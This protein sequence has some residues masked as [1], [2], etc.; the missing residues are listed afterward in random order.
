MGYGDHS[1]SLPIG[2]PR[3]METRQSEFFDQVL[4]YIKLDPKTTTNP[5]VWASN[6]NQALVDFC[7]HQNTIT[8]RNAVGAIPWKTRERSS[9]LQTLRSIG[10]EDEALTGLLDEIVRALGTKKEGEE[11]EKRPRAT[12]GARALKASTRHVADAKSKQTSSSR[13]DA[14]SDSDSL[15]LLH[16]ATN[17]VL[18]DD[19]KEAATATAT[20]T[21]AAATATEKAKKKKRVEKEAA[22]AA[23]AAEAAAAEAA[24]EK[25]KKAAAAAVAEKAAAAAAAEKAE[26]ERIAKAASVSDSRSK[27]KRGSLLP[28]MAGQ[29]T[30]IKDIGKVVSQPV[31]RSSG[32]ERPERRAGVQ[33]QTAPSSDSSSESGNES[34]GSPISS[35]KVARH[36]MRVVQGSSQRSVTASPPL[37]SATSVLEDPTTPEVHTALTAEDIELIFPSVTGFPGFTVALRNG[38][39][40]LSQAETPSSVRIFAEDLKAYAFKFTRGVQE[41]ART[42][43]LLG[44][45]ARPGASKTVDRVARLQVQSR[46]GAASYPKASSRN[47]T[48]PSLDSLSDLDSGSKGVS[49]PHSS[50]EVVSSARDNPTTVDV[51]LRGSD[52]GT[53]PGLRPSRFTGQARQMSSEALAALRSLREMAR[54]GSS[55][56]PPL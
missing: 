38:E 13:T 19:G 50:H 5:A 12:D 53:D 40:T 31:I 20:A 34:D 32:M 46:P 37:S 30:A 24:V 26:K 33:V 4:T 23:A 6:F 10:L 56:P 28:V 36:S 2:N 45:A 29:T 43:P 39:L 16:D 7:G 47:P 18:T 52:S 9:V 51:S 1:P 17:D 44:D 35:P 22:A 14:G 11:R 25:K 49:A 41:F 54:T 27:S 21:A 15:P 42:E 48:A 55:Q 3:I 8:L